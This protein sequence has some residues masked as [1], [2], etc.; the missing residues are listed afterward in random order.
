MHSAYNE[1]KSVI[2]ERIMRTW[3]NKN[4]K[5]INSVL[6]YVYIDKLDVY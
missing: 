6:K 3:K 2:A 5:Y 4:Y 1:E